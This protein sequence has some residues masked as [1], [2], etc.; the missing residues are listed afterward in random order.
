MGRGICWDRPEIMLKIAGCIVDGHD[1]WLVVVAGLVCML[2][3]HASCS[4]LHR[5]RRQEK[6]RTLWL[7]AAAIAMGCGVWA[8]HFIAMLAYRTPM[9]VGYDV[10]LTVLSALIAVCLSGVG[11]W[12]VLDRKSGVEGKSV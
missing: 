10:P 9:L 8:T 7:S 5:A 1:L 4:L 2:A 11:L 12:L 6:Q 3:S